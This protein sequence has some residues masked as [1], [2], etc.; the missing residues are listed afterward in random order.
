LVQKIFNLDDPEEAK[1]FYKDYSKVIKVPGADRTVTYDPVPRLALATSR[2]G[3][4]EA[5]ALGAY[6]FALNQ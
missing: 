5:I 4:S 1:A 6:A 3:A 2:I